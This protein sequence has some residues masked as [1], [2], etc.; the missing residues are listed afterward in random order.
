MNKLFIFCLI[1]LLFVSVVCAEPITTGSINLFA[2][3]DDDQG[4]SASLTLSLVSGTGQIWSKI[5]SLIGISTQNTEKTVVQLS[6]NY[7]DFVD[8]FD[9]KYD[10]VS[11]AKIV[12]GP[13]A[14]LPMGLLTVSMLQGKEI[15][16]YVSATGT[17]SSQGLIGA[18]GGVLEKTRVAYEKGVKLFFVPAS[19]L[20]V[21]VK[22]DGVKKVNL[23]TYAYEKYGIKVIGVDTLD[24]AFGYLETPFEDINIDLNDAKEIVIYNPPPTQ[25][26]ENMVGFA[27][28]VNSYALTLKTNIDNAKT[29]LNNT[30]LDQDVTNT[31][32][33]LI[34]YSEKLYD[35]GLS[36]KDGNYLYSA[37]NYFFLSNI[38]ANLVIDVCY[39]PTL[40]TINSTTFNE[41][42]SLLKDNLNILEK[43]LSYL[44]YDGFEWFVAAQ[45]RYL[46][47]K[48][49]VSQLDAVSVVI[50][51]QVKTVALDKLE[52]YEYAKEWVMVA[53]GFLD[54]IDSN[55]TYVSVKD[56]ADSAYTTLQEIGKSEEAINKLEPKKLQELERKIFG[57]KESY[58]K[59]WYLTSLYESATVLGIVNANILMENKS[60]S[61]L[62]PIVIEKIQTLE[63][64]MKDSNI[65]YVWSE[66]YL[67]HSK[68]FLNE[69]K[70]YKSQNNIVYTLNSLAS[71]LEL[72]YLADNLYSASSNF[73]DNRATL[74][75][76]IVTAENQENKGTVTTKASFNFG[77]LYIVIIIVALFILSIIVIY[78]IAKIKDKTENKVFK[79][80]NK[81][82][83]VIK[84]YLLDLDKKYLAGRVEDSEYILLRKD[85]NKKLIY[86]EK[87]RKAV[88]DNLED[89]AYLESQLR[90]LQNKLSRTMSFYTKNLITDGEYN[91]LVKD[92][93]EEITNI[94]YN[95][96]ADKKKL[97]KIELEDSSTVEFCKP[98]QKL[99]TKKVT[100]PVS[101]KEKTTKAIKS[102]K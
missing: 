38:N 60:Y 18:V 96:E 97:S 34:V 98:I 81:E 28:F 9:Y 94:K 17:I 91:R 27:E 93:K 6:K 64:N 26:Q 2:V 22:D 25:Y 46:W 52:K 66:L 44:P 59:G 102:K 41:N 101:K 86:L 57:A 58:N 40:L 7:V 30:L 14:G 42:V 99:K 1:S 37:A 79:D 50:N 13:S 85:Y 15:Q 76:V 67:N 69:A 63:N 36:A 10:I 3:S 49:Y 70:F 35:E 39:N 20:D 31:M 95:I 87:R 5:T 62:E 92:Y 88:V 100:K 84:N 80:V 54:N 43:K 89:L 21:V 32:L 83:T 90:Y 4:I 78:F 75:K 53:A 48:Y 77:F 72:L 82:I 8:N 11:N 19:N 51:N 16:D 74:E 29:I 24:E 23:T 47:A 65:Q 55:N 45:E 71:S 12:D 33:E 56:Y 61:E 73:Y 68:Y